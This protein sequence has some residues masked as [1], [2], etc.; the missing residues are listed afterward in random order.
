MQRTLLRWLVHWMKD[1]RRTPLILRGARQVGK[2]YLVQ[3]FGRNHFRNC[4]EVNLELEP[5]LG[6]C[7]ARLDAKAICSELE[8]L[9]GQSIIDDETLLF[10][11]EIQ[12]NPQALA[13]LRVFKEQRPG[14]HVIAAGSLLEFALQDLE[15]FSF[16][17][18]RVSFAYLQPMSFAEFLLATGQERLLESLEKV[19]V[20]SPTPA[21]VHERLL[22]VVRHYVLVGGM[23]EAV[24]AFRETGSFLEAAK[25]H[26]RLSQAF[27]ADFAKY[28]RRYDIRRLQTL[29]S[30]A[31]RLVGEHFKYSKVDR[32]SKAR[33]LKQP[34]LDLERAGLIRIVQATHATG[35]PLGSEVQDKSFKIQF[36]D[37]GLMLSAMGVRLDVPNIEEFLFA[38]EGGLAEQL[39]GG[40][41][42][43][44]A[45]A[46]ERP[47]LYF[48][49]R[50][51]R[52]SEAEV[53]FVI[54]VRGQIVPI[55]VKAG[56]TGSLRSLRLFMKERGLSLGVRVSQHPLS[57]QDGILSVPFYLVHQ[58]R[59]IV[60]SIQDKSN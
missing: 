10:I 34:L 26:R 18:G 11:D 7:F 22:Q 6:G 42:V 15:D 4:I 30:A 14:L 46:D 20:D 48:W 57:F 39:V 44:S 33:D 24:D 2:S 56:T 58:L 32:D 1:S 49:E 3:E 8:L 29:F 17:V 55:E 59:R 53:D 45:S 36:V 27:V 12:A 5:Q 37:I 23:P 35:I 28:G 43:A 25:I 41:L 21:V 40:E 51:K 52:G 38:G 13:A 16:P 19:E 31:P 47:E 60:A 50:Q 9:F 54:P